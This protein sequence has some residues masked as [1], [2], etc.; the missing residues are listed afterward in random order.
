MNFN[1]L[2]SAPRRTLSARDAVNM[3]SAFDRLEPTNDG[4]RRA[5]SRRPVVR[6]NEPC[7]S[8]CSA[9][10]NP[11]DPCIMAPVPQGYLNGVS[12]TFRDEQGHE[13][14]AWSLAGCS[15][16]SAECVQPD[17]TKGGCCYPYLYT[18][19]WYYIHVEQP[20]DKGFLYAQNAYYNVFGEW[21]H[22][23]GKNDGY[24]YALAHGD[25]KKVHR[26]MFR[27]SQYGGQSGVRGIIFSNR[28]YEIHCELDGVQTVDG[29]LKE[30]TPAYLHS[31]ANS[32]VFPAEKA[33]KE[34]SRHDVYLT[35]K[36]SFK[37][38]NDTPQVVR[39]I[40]EGEG[41]Q[42]SIHFSPWGDGVD[43]ERRLGQG[44]SKQ[45]EHCIGIETPWSTFS[46]RTNRFERPTR[47][48]SY[49][50]RARLKTPGWTCADRS[51]CCND[52]V[53]TARCESGKCGVG[54]ITYNF[55]G[56]ETRGPSSY[57]GSDRC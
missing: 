41:V 54:L 43:T 45:C 26:F 50:Q 33:L 8:K 24:Y 9:Q 42:I 53:D 32:I 1:H 35:L 27:D 5:L 15:D 7:P 11:N 17:G 6:G 36:M 28:K 46:I 2:Q 14:V 25:P 12:R 56:W 10:S 51:P 47:S 23:Q 39:P 52:P 57:C 31:Y 16:Q 19:T 18:N 21:D 34:D 49:D 37:S 29:P 13:N 3:F 22:D 30:D 44:K 38:N 40:F 55:P 48:L 20:S 4:N